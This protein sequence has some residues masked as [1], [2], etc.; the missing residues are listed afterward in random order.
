MYILGR[1][2][3]YHDRN[4]WA[5]IWAALS[6]QDELFIYRCWSPDLNKW[7]NATIAKEVASLSGTERFTLNLID[8]L[9]KKVQTNTGKSA[10]E[11]L[12]EE[13]FRLRRQGVG[14]GG[15]W[16]PYDTK[17]A[18]GRDAIKTRLHNSIRVER[19]FN[20]R[21]T[22]EGREI[23]LPTIWILRRCGEVAR[24]LRQWR[25]EEWGSSKTLVTKD[26]KETPSQKFSHFPTA[27]EG[28][29]KD[30]RFR[31]R[32]HLAHRTIQRPTHFQVGR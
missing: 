22:E 26:R 1:A 19:P 8:P 10:L 16:E 21:I 13:F 20:N 23:W 24:S 28:L 17:G 4:P 6:P 31:A 12:N 27:L 7:V 3:D 2:I 14:T 32:K 5:I 18:V 15:Y 9:A 30:R 29:L 11:D 25:Y